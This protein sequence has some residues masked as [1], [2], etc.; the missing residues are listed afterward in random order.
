MDVT[1]QLVRGGPVP[2]RVTVPSAVHKFH[3]PVTGLVPAEAACVEVPVSCC[4]DSGPCA[5]LHLCKAGKT[6]NSSAPVFNS[7][8]FAPSL[9]DEDH[10]S[11][12]WCIFRTRLSHSNSSEIHSIRF[13]IF[14][15]SLHL[16][17]LSSLTTEKNPR[18]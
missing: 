9:N 2:V 12:T 11:C 4:L 10:M 14:L 5:I 18:H 1:E 6:P 3:G 15:F 16:E 7:R 13:H 8:M 17:F